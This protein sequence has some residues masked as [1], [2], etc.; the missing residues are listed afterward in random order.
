[1][2]RA[3]RRGLYD[4]VGADPNIDNIVTRCSN[5]QRNMVNEPHCKISYDADACVAVPLPDPATEYTVYTSDPGSGNPEPLYK[6]SPD[7]AGP[8]S[9]CLYLRGFVVHLLFG[10][11]Y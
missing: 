8:V 1:M 5:V 2:K 3:A 7:Y 10:I 6:F 4:M 11:C 9:I